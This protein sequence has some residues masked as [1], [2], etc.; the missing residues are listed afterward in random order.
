[1]FLTDI[2]QRIITGCKFVRE[3]HENA[4]ELQRTYANQGQILVTLKPN[5]EVLFMLP[6][7]SSTLLISWLG[8]FQ[9]ISSLSKLIKFCF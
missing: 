4:E 2:K 9:V 1:M 3:N 7:K 8:L 6:D 5:D